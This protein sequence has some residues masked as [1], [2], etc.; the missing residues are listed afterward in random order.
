LPIYPARE[1]PLPGITSEALAAAF[2]E[3]KRPQ[4][5]SP[6][7]AVEWVLRTHPSLLMTLGAGDIDRLVSVFEDHFTQHS[8]R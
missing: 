6:Q 1:L 5:L 4:V 2:P 3:E 8:Q 7:A